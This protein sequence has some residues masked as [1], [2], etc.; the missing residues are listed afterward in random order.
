MLCCYYPSD[1]KP[2][3]FT[4]SPWDL[5]S[6]ASIQDTPLLSTPLGTGGSLTNATNAD[7]SQAQLT[8]PDDEIDDDWK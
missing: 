5:P 3:F 6:K 2:G 4:E 7:S 1:K 8:Y